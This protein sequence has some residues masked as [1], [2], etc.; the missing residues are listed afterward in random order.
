MAELL[1]TIS[2]PCPNQQLMIFKIYQRNPYFLQFTH[3]ECKVHRIQL[4]ERSILNLGLYIFILTKCSY[5]INIFF[6]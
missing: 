3:Y 4:E 1:R 2:Y 5:N 6:L